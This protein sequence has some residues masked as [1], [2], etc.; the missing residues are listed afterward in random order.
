M[1]KDWFLVGSLL[2]G[3]LVFSAGCSILNAPS[4]VIPAGEAGGAGGSPSTS[5]SSSSSSGMGGAGGA[6]ICEPGAQSSCYDADP[7]TAGIGEC[8][9]GVS[10]CAPDGSGYGPCEGQVLPALIDKCSTPLYDE[11]CDG[12][13]NDGCPGERVAVVAAAPAGYANEVLNSLVGTMSFI[14]GQVYDAGTTTPTLAEL[15]MFQSVLVF[16]ETAFADPV[17]L[18]DVL[19]AYFDSGGRV[20]LAMYTT[21]GTGTRIQGKFGDPSMGYMLL[22]SA[23]GLSGPVDDTLGPVN[24][25]E[26]RLMRNVTTFSYTG[27]VKSNG[28]VINGGVV[29]AEWASKVPLIVTGDM[30]GRNRVDLNFYPPRNQGMNTAWTGDGITMIRNAL[31]Y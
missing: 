16:S 14:V 21:T 10:T 25:P 8:R 30:K 3:G 23:A 27:S 18:G 5:S 22:D 29:V 6:M 24:D 20:V 28:P 13:E 15:Q 26:N 1:N 11:N 7:V 9:M 17:A 19:A 31:L 4:E 12:V 2:F